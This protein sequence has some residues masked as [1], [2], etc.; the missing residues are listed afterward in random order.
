MTYRNIYLYERKLFNIKIFL[1]NGYEN[2]LF[3]AS[4]KIC[5]LE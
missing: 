2:G 3:M 1:K 5:L 4:V